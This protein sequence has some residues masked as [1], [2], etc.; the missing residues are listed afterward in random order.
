MSHQSIYEVTERMSLQGITDAVKELNGTVEI[1]RC[2][3]G[4]SG[5]VG[6]CTHR[7]H[8]PGMKYDIGITVDKDGIVT[9]MSTDW[10]GGYVAKIV[11]RDYGI[12]KR[13]YAIAVTTAELKRKGMQFKR[14]N[15]NGK[16]QIEVYT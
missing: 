4:Y 9:S 6:G 8:I 16:H 3:I 14:I 10:W 11:G 5:P 12:L 2:F 13:E 1:S 7:I 15:N